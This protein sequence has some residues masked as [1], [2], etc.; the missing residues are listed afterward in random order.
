MIK[1][2]PSETVLAGE[3]IAA[4]GQVHG[5]ATCER[6]ASLL[7][8]GLIRVCADETGWDTLY[9]DPGDDRYWELT[10]P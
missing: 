7:D 3:W 9:R 2:A 1:L 6:I 5:D 4:D 8:G 10:Y